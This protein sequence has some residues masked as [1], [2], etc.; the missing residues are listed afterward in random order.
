MGK[1]EREK[2]REREREKET[3]R[4]KKRVNEGERQRKE[5]GIEIEYLNGRTPLLLS[6]TVCPGSSDPPEKIFNIFAPEN[7]VYTIY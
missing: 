2:E 4:Q 7:E 6:H 5:E 3:G 1:R